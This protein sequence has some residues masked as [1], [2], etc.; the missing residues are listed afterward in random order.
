M[1]A[2]DFA[3][4]CRAEGLEAQATSLGQPL[5]Y[6]AAEASGLGMRWIEVQVMKL[7]M[8]K[9]KQSAATNLTKT[10]NSIQS[11]LQSP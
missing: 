4:I 3:E 5:D 9:V 10:T 11:S 6:V 7:H 8:A 1:T 2:A